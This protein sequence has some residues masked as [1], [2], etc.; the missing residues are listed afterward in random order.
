MNAISWQARLG[1]VLVSCSIIV[2]LTK[3][4]LIDNIPGTIEYIFNSFGFL[5]INVLLVTLV[6]NELL[7]RRARNARLE[8]LNMVIGIFFT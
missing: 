5:F 7:S 3:I 2:Y 6:I 8:K 4:T 1:M